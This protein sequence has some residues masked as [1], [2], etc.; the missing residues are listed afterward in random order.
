MKLAILDLCLPH[1]EFEAHGPI[2]RMVRDW[3]APHLPEADMS[4]LY[5]ADGVPLPEVVSFDGYI[6]TGSEKGVYDD[7]AW[8][9]PLTAFLH[10][11]RE[12]RIPVFGV[13]FGHQIMAE[14]FGGKAEKADKGFVVGA[15]SYLTDTGEFAAH[16]MHQDQVTVP[17]PGARI[18]AS[19]P[20]CPVAAL[21]YDFPALS[22]QFHPE[23]R[24]DF[25]TG[26]V[27]VFE[28]E[29]LTPDE[30]AASRR[31]FALPVA[32]GLYGEDTARFFRSTLA[33]G[34]TPPQAQSGKT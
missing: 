16:A 27:D 9:K 30:A 20:Y 4:I 28:G 21:A 24:Q 14:A 17:P 32:H 10:A 23:Y 8:M 31:S 5:I 11:L 3:L 18:T 1:K 2:G 6:L 15:R 22:V 12:R 7:T 25:V 33:N 13:C 34:R 29:L 26:A 19:A